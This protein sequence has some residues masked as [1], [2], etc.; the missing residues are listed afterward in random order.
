MSSHPRISYFFNHLSPYS[1]LCHSKLPLSIILVGVGDG[2]WD[3]MNE[4]DDNIPDRDF[5]NF[6]VSNEEHKKKLHWSFNSTSISN[7]N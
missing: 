3:L 7:G 5:D 1:M 4:F 2:P 6:H